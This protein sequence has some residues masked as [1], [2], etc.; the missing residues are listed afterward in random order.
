MI[1][2]N[3][4][5]FKDDI[6]TKIEKAYEDNSIINY[7]SFIMINPITPDSFPNF[8]EPY[9]THM[10]YT[11]RHLLYK[12]KKG[13]ITSPRQVM[14]SSDECIS[15]VHFIFDNNMNVTD[16]NIFQRSSNINNLK[17]DIQFLNYFI[18]K[19]IK[20]P[21]TLSIFISIPHRFKNKKTK[22]DEEI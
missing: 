20:H 9:Y 22:V 12:F 13:W 1:V 6:S 14:F 17:E 21:I 2:L 15:N 10:E 11:L 18:N 7:R 3:N 19:Y 8:D 4:F 16:M 5:D